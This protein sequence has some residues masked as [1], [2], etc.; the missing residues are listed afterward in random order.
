MNKDKLVDLTAA[1]ISE[2]IFAAVGMMLLMWALPKCANEP[3]HWSHWFGLLVGIKAIT[4]RATL[5][6]KSKA[7]QPETQ[8]EAVS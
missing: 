7:T 1:A 2:I 5:K 3:Y 4:H 6:S 8:D